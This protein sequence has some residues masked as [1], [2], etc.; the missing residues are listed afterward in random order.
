[1]L[2]LIILIIRNSSGGFPTQPPLPELSRIVTVVQDALH[3]LVVF[4]KNLVFL[5]HYFVFS[6]Y[7]G[8][9]PTLTGDFL[10]KNSIAFINAVYF[11]VQSFDFFV[12]LFTALFQGIE[13]LCHFT[14][15]LEHILF[16]MITH[17]S[18]SFTQNYY[19]K[20]TEN[21]RK[22]RIRVV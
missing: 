17:E 4:T 1:M 13:T 11:L 7:F 16:I 20:Y 18:T 12:V 21:N 6:S 8:E 2:I 10:F 9:L 19:K 22:K 15:L 3:T 14:E 5:L